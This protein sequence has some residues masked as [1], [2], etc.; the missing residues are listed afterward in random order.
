M[1][2]YLGIEGGAKHLYGML[3]RFYFGAERIGVQLPTVG[4][5]VDHG[6]KQLH[7]HTAAKESNEE[8]GE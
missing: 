7:K 3:Q 4:T 1:T 2:L 6:L 8:I 5:A